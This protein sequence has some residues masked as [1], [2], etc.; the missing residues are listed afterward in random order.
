MAKKNTSRRI[1]PLK[2]NT[3]SGKTVDVRKAILERLSAIGKS[4]NWLAAQSGLRI[5][6]V[7]EYLAGDKDVWAEKA[8]RMLTAL[9]LEIRPKGKARR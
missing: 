3:A 7:Y 8:E 1:L 9:D 6:T 5:A 2:V 4:R